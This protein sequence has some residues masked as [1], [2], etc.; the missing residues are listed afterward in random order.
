MDL[1]KQISRMLS[2]KDQAIHSDDSVAEPN[3]CPI[4][5]NNE[6]VA[7]PAPIGDDILTW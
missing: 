7:A 6:I 1:A 4:C 5:Y 3:Y 2:I